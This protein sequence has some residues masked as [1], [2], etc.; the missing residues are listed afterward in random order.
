[1][2]APVTPELSTRTTKVHLLYFERRYG[3]ARLE[4]VWKEAGLALPLSH[5]EDLNQFVSLDFVEEVFETLTSASG[6]P[7]F[8][9]T[10][11]LEMATPE[12]LGFAYFLLKAVGRPSLMYKK[13]IELG[14][15]Y[16]RVGHFNVERLLNNAMTLT[17]R[18]SR[19]ERTRLLCRARQAN[20]SCFP[21]I[22]KLPL[23]QVRETQCQVTGADCCRYE[24]EWQNPLPAWRRY[25]GFAL[26]GAAGYGAHALGLAPVAFASPALALAGGSLGAWLDLRVELDRKSQFL[27]SQSEGMAQSLADLAKANVELEGR[28]TERTQELSTANHRLADALERQKEYDRL[29]TEFFDNVSHELRTPLTVI[30]LSL[31][32]LGHHQQLDAETRNNL[33]AIDRSTNRLLRLINDLLDLA[34][35]EARQLRLHYVP[36]ELGDFLGSILSPLQVLAKQKQLTLKLEGRPS[37]PVLAD[38]DKLESVFQNLV[39]NALKFTSKGS[40]TVR[41]SESAEHVRIEVVDTGAGI[42]EAD[43]ARIFDRFAQSDVHG[44]RRFGGTGI[45]LALT[46]EIVKLHG[47][48][49]EVQSRLGVGSTFIVELPKGSAHVREDLK[50]A[51]VPAGAGQSAP[52]RDLLTL[53]PT[54]IDVH[55]PSAPEVAASLTGTGIGQKTILVVEDEAEVRRLLVSTLRRRFRVVEAID[56]DDGLQ[57]ALTERPDLIVS[58][59]MMPV[60][61][62][63]QL[64]KTLRERKEIAELPVIL[65]TARRE[66]EATLA[67]LGAGANDY[68]GKPFSPRELLARVDTQLALRDAAARAA[69]NERLAT[70]GLITASFAHEVRNPLNGIINALAPLRESLSTDPQTAKEMLEILAGCSERVRHISEALLAFTRPTASRSEVDVA[71]GLAASVKVLDWKRPAGVEITQS[72]QGDCCPEGD[73]GALNQVWVNLLDNALRAVGDRGK[74]EISSMC[75]GQHCVVRIHDDGPGIADEVRSKLFQPFVTNRPSGEGTGLGLALCQRIVQAHG[76]TIEASSLPGQGTT[77]TVRIPH[78]HSEAAPTR[79]TSS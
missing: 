19:P 32:A 36:I 78:Q 52:E 24:F 48:T 14:P 55:E 33:A 39:Q 31:E 15:S 73:P 18:S 54:A 10:A 51:P 72:A 59:V 65:L 17:Y 7:D 66:L 6:D 46:Q 27:D 9:F 40:V 35:L 30:L 38:A 69:Q 67:G 4:Q 29:K 44:V 41:L 64:L 50:A 49:L 43:L 28:V 79:A 74:I 3:R 71:G 34:K 20:F 75:E 62:G 5:M 57:K 45:G 11:G 16:N 42:P 47:G 77:F 26:G 21:T 22:W 68:V 25:A 13:T 1:M 58:D 70:M 61:S 53:R 37:A 8:C 60:K 56:G 63:L 2:I 12:A 23:A 76:G